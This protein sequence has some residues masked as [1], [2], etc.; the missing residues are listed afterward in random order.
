MISGARVN[1]AA[2]YPIDYEGTRKKAI[3]LLEQAL[4]K[5]LV[6]RDMYDDMLKHTVEQHDDLI[7]EKLGKIEREKTKLITIKD[8]AEQA[9]VGVLPAALSDEAKRF[10]VHHRCR[11]CK[12]LIAAVPAGTEISVAACPFCGATNP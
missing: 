11:A 6:P 2:I 10:I 12:L 8:G 4:G 5:A 9:L 3:D 7:L 1:P